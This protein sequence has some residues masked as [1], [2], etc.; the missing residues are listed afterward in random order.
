MSGS[1]VAKVLSIL[2]NCFSRNNL[3]F[4]QEKCLQLKEEAPPAGRN[5]EI[6]VPYKRSRVE[7]VSIENSTYLLNVS[8]IVASLNYCKKFVASKIYV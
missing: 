3:K 2:C 5:T 4:L 6:K 8:I 7:H 1:E